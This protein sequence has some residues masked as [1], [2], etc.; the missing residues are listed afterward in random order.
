[1][2]DDTEILKGLLEGCILDIICKNDTYGYEI[3]EKLHDFGF[4]DVVDGTV[5]TILRRIEKK[6]LVE[7]KTESSSKGPS[8]RIYSLN[9]NGV[10]YLESFWIR[11]DFISKKINQIKSSS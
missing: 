9:D 7:I 4:N 2:K 8:R 6:D 11:W 5:Y 10:R 3:M 1:M